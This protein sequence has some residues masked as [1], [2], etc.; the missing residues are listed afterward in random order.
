MLD[1]RVC[2]PPDLNAG[3]SEA[4]HAATIADL[5]S[6]GLFDLRSSSSLAAALSAARRAGGLARRRHPHRSLGQAPTGPAPKPTRDT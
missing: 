6:M 3:A 5:T 2:F 1:Y 4:A